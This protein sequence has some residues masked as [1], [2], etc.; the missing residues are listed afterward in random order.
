M[1]V[2]GSVFVFAPESLL[3][4]FRSRDVS[5]SDFASVR[6]AGVVL[7]RFIALYMFFDALSLVYSG[8]LRGAGDT[9]FVMIAMTI[10]CLVF[11]V[12]PVYTGIEHLDFGLRASWTCAAIY[13]CMLGVMFRWRYRQGKW[14]SM[15]VIETV[16]KPATE[17]ALPNGTPA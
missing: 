9:R 10:N 2:T 7:L 15:R 11:M 3:E 8:A 12:V 13:I 17:P 16:P 5:A 14:K 6:D 4:L 1:V